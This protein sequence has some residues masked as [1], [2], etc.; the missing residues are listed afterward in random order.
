MWGVLAVGI[1]VLAGCSG[2]DI[3]GAIDGVPVK[4]K[5][6]FYFAETD[7][8]A[9]DDLV[10]VILSDLKDACQ[11]YGYYLESTKDMEGADDFASAW[12]AVF[13]PDF[14]EVAIIFRVAD[15]QVPLD[16]AQLVGLDWDETLDQRNH[17]FAS[18]VHNRAI[19][20]ASFFDGSGPTS[21]YL[22]GYVS[23]GG[24]IEITKHI[25]GSYIRGNFGTEVVD[26]EEGETK[27]LVKMKFNAPFCDVDIL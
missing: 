9:E 26:R 16:G 25:P 1:P 13:P 8:L 7:A 14:W 3:N 15:S 4:V 19:R 27:G 18:F 2:S 11:D 12:A 22:D 17:G 21:D 20:D 23:R 24:R 10:T 5:S 6:A